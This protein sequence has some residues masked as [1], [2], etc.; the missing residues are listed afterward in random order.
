MKTSKELVSE[1]KARIESVTADELAKELES[2]A[3]VVVDIR[4]SG[5]RKVGHIPGAI[6]I[7]RGD[8]EFCADPTSEFA[9]HRIG[10]DKRIVVH[11]ALGLAGA[12]AA[13]TLQDMGYQRVANL[14]GGYEAWIASG[15]TAETA[16]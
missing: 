12:L 11:C 3:V 2:G 15:R 4:D 9:D 13:A 16:S 6:H 8:L 10:P 1:A 7:P 5:E 14:E